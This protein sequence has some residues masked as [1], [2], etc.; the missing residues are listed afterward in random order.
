[1]QGYKPPISNDNVAQSCKIKIELDAFFVPIY[2]ELSLK[3]AYMYQ[4][5][6][7]AADEFYERNETYM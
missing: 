2:K 5:F 7:T 6:G 1:M 3:N 4:P